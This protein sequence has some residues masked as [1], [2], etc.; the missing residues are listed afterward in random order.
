M[1]PRHIASATHLPKDTTGYLAFDI[2][3]AVEFSR[4]GR[5]PLPPFLASPEGT[6]H[7]IVAFAFAP[8]NLSN[9]DQDLKPDDQ[10]VILKFDLVAI[11]LE[12]EKL[13]GFPHLWGDR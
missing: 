3:H 13:F 5:S 8:G 10:T 11:P 4:I 9:L 12:A 1:C 7:T 6:S 2:V